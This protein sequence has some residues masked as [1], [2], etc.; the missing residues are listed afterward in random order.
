MVAVSKYPTA[1]DIQ[2]SIKGV[3]Q[4]QLDS[5]KAQ[6]TSERPV[7]LGDATGTDYD[8]ASADLI[9]HVRIYVTP[10]TL[11]QIMVIWS[12]N[13][14]PADYDRYVNSFHFVTD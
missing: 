1:I 3:K 13:K 2:G 6:I 9:G 7:S 4:A 12:K 10:K 8:M 14:P 11:Y 5:I